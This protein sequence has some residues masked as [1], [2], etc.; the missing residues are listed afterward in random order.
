MFVVA[1]YLASGEFDKLKAQ[2]VADRRDQD[3]D[4]CPNKTLPMAVIHLVLPMKI[5]IKG[6]FMQMPMTGEPTQ[7]KL[8]KDMMQF[9]SACFQNQQKMLKVLYGC[10]Q[11]SALWYALIRR[12]LEEQGY[13]FNEANPCVFRK[14]KWGQNLH[15]VTVC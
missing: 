5:N 10:T 9:E 11:A 12:F 4:L 13:T 3:A 15:F 7:R 6:A 8:D 1:K 14:Q 2:L